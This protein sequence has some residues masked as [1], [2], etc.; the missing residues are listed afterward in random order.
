M[1]TL[2]WIEDK[3]LSLSFHW[4]LAAD[5]KAAITEAHHLSDSLIPRPKIVPGEKVLNCLPP[6]IPDKSKAIQQLL[7]QRHLGQAL[8]IGD[9]W[10]DATVFN[11]WD[12]RINGVEVGEKELGAFWMVPDQSCVEVLLEI[13]SDALVPPS[14]SFAS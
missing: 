4:R 1:K 6:G 12:P 3:G 10:T 13:M 11:S 14:G 7:D 9:V 8:F 5:Q 2:C